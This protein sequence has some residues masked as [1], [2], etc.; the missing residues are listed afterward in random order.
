VNRWWHIGLCS[1]AASGCLHAD[2]SRLEAGAPYRGLSPDA[3]RAGLDSYECAMRRG[4]IKRPGTLTIIDYSKSSSERRLWVFDIDEGILVHR[5]L[6]S[7]GKNSGEDMAVEFS[8]IVDS[9]QTSIGVFRTAE[10]Y[11]GKHGR[12]LR[13][14]GLEPSFNDAA[15]A[16]DIVIHSAEYVC[17]DH[18]REEGRLGRSWGCPAL[19]LGTAQAIIDRIAEGTLLVAYY[20]DDQWLSES[21]YLHCPE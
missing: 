15:R 1:I 4:D 12:S 11:E 19:P 9:N 21:A 5:E 10:T 17:E 6:V 2:L 20:P 13:L 16:R 18:V 14:D 8:N 7:H 3:F